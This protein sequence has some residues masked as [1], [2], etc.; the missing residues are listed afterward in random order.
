[1]T[2]ANIISFLIFQVLPVVDENRLR[3]STEEMTGMIES[4]KLF[5]YFDAHPMDF[6]VN[7]I[8]PDDRSYIER[9]LKEID[10][11]YG[12][13]RVGAVYNGFCTLLSYLAVLLD[14]SIGA[15]EAWDV[16]RFQA[17][18]K[19]KIIPPGRR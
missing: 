12:S 11:A 19:I 18:R 14:R 6:N 8:K 7:V 9:N 5:D 2:R 3:I 16:K 1:M 15:S 13:R 17:E 10:R 4:E